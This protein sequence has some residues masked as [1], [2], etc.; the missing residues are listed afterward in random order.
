[1]KTGAA[2]GTEIAVGDECVNRITGD[3]GTVVAFDGASWD[4]STN[5]SVKIGSS[6]VVAFPLA[7][8]APVPEPAN[9][10]TAAG[11]QHRVQCGDKLYRDGVL[12]GTVHH[13]D[14]GAGGE[15][16][17][18]VRLDAGNRRR[19]MVAGTYLYATHV[20]LS[21]DQIAKFESV[22]MER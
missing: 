9:G 11:T 12:F 19:V 7:D 21:Y 15:R 2:Y 6:I 22:P 18:S 14:V 8:L 20:F 5:A 16:G 4:D 3:R 1:M 17:A 13:W 10:E